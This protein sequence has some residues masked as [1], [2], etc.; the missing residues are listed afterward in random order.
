M[1]SVLVFGY[2]MDRGIWR[3]V[4]S[5]VVF[6]VTGSCAVLSNTY[7]RVRGMRLCD[8]FGERIRRYC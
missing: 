5:D 7:Q 3:Y 8:T 4:L 2:S 1:D 6:V